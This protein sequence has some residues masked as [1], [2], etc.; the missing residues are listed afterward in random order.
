M[1]NAVRVIRTKKSITLK[2]IPV[3]A[4]VRTKN[5]VALIGFPF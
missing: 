4:V 2:L 3:A 5:T 1:I